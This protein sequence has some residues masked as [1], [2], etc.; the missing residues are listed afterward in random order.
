M[1]AQ[2]AD[3]RH[4]WLYLSGV[5]MSWLT[6]NPNAMRRELFELAREA[7]GWSEEY[8][9]GKLSSVIRR[10]FGAFA[11]EKIEYQGRQVDPRYRFTNQRIIEELEI[12][13]AEEREMR[14]IISDDERRRRDRARKNPEM[15]RQQY[16][17]RAAKR[18]AQARRMASK[19][20][21][22]RQIARELE[23]SKSQV[24]RALQ[25]GES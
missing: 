25:E 10:T 11:G 2:M 1:D 8:A 16:L 20:L 24:H 12:D 14:T 17:T 19:G 23:I 9:A 13:F 4:R 22:V 15:D 6:V 21:S 3:Y 18:R 7:G 5:A